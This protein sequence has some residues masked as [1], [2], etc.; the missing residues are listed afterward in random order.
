MAVESRL[1]TAEEFY[2]LP[3]DGMRLE[4]IDGEVRRRV[5]P[6]SQHGW[7][8]VSISAHLFAFSSE[9]P[10]V[11]VFAETGFLVARNPDRVLA[12][13]VAVVSSDRVPP[14]GI[15]KTYFPGPPDLAIEIVSPN[16]T[17]IEVL[18]KVQDWFAGGARL[19]WAFY[20]GQPG[21]VVH[22]PD[23]SSQILGP[24]DEVEGGDVLAGFRMKV[25]DLLHPFKR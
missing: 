6:G 2:T 24:N 21:L 8:M 7:S 9:H 17:A 23:G 11:Q 19:V 3:D 15:P 10:E 22:R 12:P 25:A 1:L 16:D 13:D 14:G 5:P 4:L 18:E 20:P